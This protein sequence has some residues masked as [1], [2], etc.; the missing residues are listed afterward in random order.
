[1]S[2]PKARQKN[3]RFGHTLESATDSLHGK[4]LSNLAGFLG[5]LLPARCEASPVLYFGGVAGHF[6]MWSLGHI[7]LALINVIQLVDIELKLCRNKRD[8]SREEDEWGF[9]Q[10]LALLLLVVPVRDFV[11]SILDIREN[12]KKEKLAREATQR[13]FKE[14]LQ[15]AVNNDTFCE[16][17]GT[18]DHFGNWHSFDLN[19]TI[20]GWKKTLDHFGDLNGASAAKEIQLL[21]WG[22]PWQSPAT[23]RQ[24]RFDKHNATV[25]LEDYL[26]SSF[27]L[28]L[29]FKSSGISSTVLE[30]AFGPIIFV[31][32]SKPL[33][34]PFWVIPVV[35]LL[36][37]KRLEFLRIEPDPGHLGHAY[38]LNVSAGS[39]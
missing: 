21:R 26:K 10:V 36:I 3:S 16:S 19:H 4:F 11:T 31:A 33:A 23:A 22:V 18:S 7:C 39:K 15:E 34:N 28:D 25:Q 30:S 37:S 6:G 29:K 14:H 2:E 32:D 38:S 35:T 8:Q 17:N 13:T 1:M 24:P 20:L 12:V 27:K 5:G 9:G